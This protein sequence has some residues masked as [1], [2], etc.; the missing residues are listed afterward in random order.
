MDRQ[1][2]TVPPVVTTQVN[3]D[4]SVTVTVTGRHGT[5]SLI[6]SGDGPDIAI[7]DRERT[8]RLRGEDGAD[9]FLASF[10]VAVN[11][12]LRG[13]FVEKKGITG[14]DDTLAWFPASVSSTPK[15]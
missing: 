9:M 3:E 2:F 6:V 14:V 15:H 12:Q 10:E 7:L 11:G 1:S 4:G 13:W 5:V 8:K